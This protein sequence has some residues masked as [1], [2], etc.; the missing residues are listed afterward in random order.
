MKGML[1]A[2]VAAAAVLA[3]AGPAFGQGAKVEKGK[4]LFTA[5]KCTNCHSIAGKGN[6]KGSLDDVGSK[7]TAAQIKQWITDPE[8]MAA[9]EN[10][11]RKPPMKKKA[12]SNDEV[13]SLVA[14]LSTLKK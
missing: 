2:V 4:E 1:T 11:T 10:A 14:Y 8:G 12:L 13:D 6:K 7:L 3:L 5:Q 9:K